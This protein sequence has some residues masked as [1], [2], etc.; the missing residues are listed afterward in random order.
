MD[1]SPRNWQ[2]PAKV[3]NFPVYLLIFSTFPTFC[4]FERIS[5]YFLFMYSRYVFGRGCGA[6]P[7]PIAGLRGLTSK[8]KRGG[9]G[10]KGVRQGTEGEER[11]KEQGREWRGSRRKGRTAEGKKACRNSPSS[12]PVYPLESSH[13]CQKNSQ[14]AN[15]VH[16]DS[17]TRF[18]DHKLRLPQRVVGDNL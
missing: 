12:I 18:S 16:V 14:I 6:S 10:R 8:G 4:I 2:F 15:R 5:N 11:G 7:D 9:N 17:N 3:C 1:R 13:H